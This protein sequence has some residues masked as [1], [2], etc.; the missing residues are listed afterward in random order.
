MASWSPTVCVID[1]LQAASDGR[2]MPSS[3]MQVAVRAQSVAV[4]WQLLS[5]S[6][7]D[8]SEDEAPCGLSQIVSD[9]AEQLQSI[10]DACG[11]DDTLSDVTVRAQADL[12]LVFDAAK[13]QVPISAVMFC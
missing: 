13:L 1:W 7:E 5:L 11:N 8:A 12:Y 10:G 9:F 6:D 3:I 4:T 2:P